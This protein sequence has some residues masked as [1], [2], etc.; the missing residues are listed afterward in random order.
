MDWFLMC[1][2]LVHGTASLVEMNDGPYALRMGVNRKFDFLSRA[3][4]CFCLIKFLCDLG[5]PQADLPGSPA[6]RMGQ[7]RI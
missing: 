7:R 6:Q 4:C 3:Y 2:H 1:R 5:K